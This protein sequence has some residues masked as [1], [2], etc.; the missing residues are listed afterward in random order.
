MAIAP[1]RPAAAAND[2]ATTPTTAVA[3]RGPVNYTTQGRRRANCDSGTLAALG[4]RSILLDSHVLKDA[5]AHRL[6]LAAPPPR[7]PRRRHQYYLIRSEPPAAQ[8][9]RATLN[10][11]DVYDGPPRR[12]RRFGSAL[13]G[14]RCAGGRLNLPRSAPLRPAPYRSSGDIT[15]GVGQNYVTA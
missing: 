13:A 7:R 6:P 15:P 5:P 11:G 14:G 1:P 2:A 8:Y 9:G 10:R 3:Q 12:R 4:A